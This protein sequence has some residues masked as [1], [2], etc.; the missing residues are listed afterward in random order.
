MKDREKFIQ[1]IVSQISK[2]KYGKEVA[3]AEYEKGKYSEFVIIT[4]IDGS[5]KYI[6]ITG[7]SSVTILND[8]CSC[9]NDEK[10]PIYQ[11]QLVVGKIKK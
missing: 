11:R 6:C 4:F 7:K 8:I 1:E 10:N 2:H 9:L 3:K 5:Q